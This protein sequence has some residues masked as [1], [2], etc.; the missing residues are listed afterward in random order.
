[1]RPYAD[2]FLAEL[3]GIGERGWM[4]SIMLAA[5]MVP[6]AG[7]DEGYLDRLEPA[8][9]HRGQRDGPPAGA[10]AL[11]HD[12]PDAAGALADRRMR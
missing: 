5:T 9:R 12:A 1:M 8:A 10:R 2:A 4:T 11:R 7:V 3:P 6:K